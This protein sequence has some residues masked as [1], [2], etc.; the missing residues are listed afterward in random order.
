M[1][2]IDLK[3][4]LIGLLLG[5]NLMFLFGANKQSV[6]DVQIVSIKPK[7]AMPI[8][9]TVSMLRDNVINVRVVD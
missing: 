2:K 5:T 4:L 8:T 3:S 1:K 6:Q 7:V 9:N